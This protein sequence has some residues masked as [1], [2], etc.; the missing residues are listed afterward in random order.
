MRFFIIDIE[1]LDPYARHWIAVHAILYR[2]NTDE[3]E[4]SFTAYVKREEKASG[5]QVTF[6]ERNQMAANFLSNRATED[7][8]TAEDRFVKWLDDYIFPAKDVTMVADNAPYE[9]QWMNRILE[10]HQHAP[11]QASFNRFLH[12]ICL[13][14]MSLFHPIYAPNSN[15]VRTLQSSGPPHTPERDVGDQLYKALSYSTFFYGHH[16]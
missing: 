6:W 15:A 11:F 14:T 5:P 1:A 3:I 12:P 10:R 16:L 2:V 8:K 13:A 4:Q 9:M 7:E